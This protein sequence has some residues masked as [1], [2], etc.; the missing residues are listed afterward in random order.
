MGKIIKRGAEAV[1][2]LDGETLAKERVKKGYRLEALDEKIRK[3]RTGRE[4]R[5]MLK[6]ERA[7]VFVPKIA[8]TDRFK[9][10]MEYL[11][12]GTVKK[13]LTGLKERERRRVCEMIGESIAKMHSNGIMHGDLT[14]SNMI[15]SGGRVYFIDFGLGKPSQRVEDFATDLYLLYEAL[16]STHFE[17][18]KGVWEMILD[19]Y[20]KHNPAAEEVLN[21]LERIRK[22]RRYKG[23]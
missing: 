19:A 17:L 21:R 2:R 23:R 13:V 16:I 14:T 15:Y 5:L 6:A 20:K 3:Q 7:G 1:L 10:K 11:G 4:S 22:R 9:I 12:K 8:V 18:H